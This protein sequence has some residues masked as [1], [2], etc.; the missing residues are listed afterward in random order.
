MLVGQE[1]VFYCLTVM[2]EKYPHPPMPEGAAPGIVQGMYLLREA[3]GE[4]GQRGAP[5]VQLLGSGTILR[6]VIAAAEL[7][8]QDFG[9]AADV[10]SVT[11]WTELRREGMAVERRN[12][13]HPDAEP[14]RS[15]VERCLTPRTG[16]VL[17]ASDSMRLVA[18]QIRPWVPRRFVALGTDGY[19]RSDTRRRLRRFFEV[20]REHV[21]VAALRALADD[22]RVD[23]ARVGEAIGKY[24]LDAE[25]PAPWTV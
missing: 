1:N 8:Q 5:R 6:E 20:D 12:R 21:A 15:Y 22:G 9:V 3:D 16:P 25:K 23:R 14:Q 11:S 18:D 19:G 7:L 24:G 17:A 13:L 4:A 10:W 2:N